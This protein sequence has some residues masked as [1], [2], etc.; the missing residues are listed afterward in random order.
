MIQTEDKIRQRELRDMIPDL[1]GAMEEAG[2]IIANPESIDRCI[3]HVRHGVSIEY[4]VAVSI[5]TEGKYSVTVSSN[6]YGV[7]RLIAKMKDLNS[8]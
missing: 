4:K 5:T 7:K 8:D 2:R 1:K 3:N 6:T